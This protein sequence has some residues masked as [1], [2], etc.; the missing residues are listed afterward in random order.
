VVRDRVGTCRWPVGS[1]PA[2]GCDLA[3]HTPWPRG[4]TEAPNL[5]PLAR[6]A[7]RGKT[8]AGFRPRRTTA[9]T[10]EW[11][12]PTGHVYTVLDDPLQAGDWL[13]D[14]EPPINWPPDFYQPDDWITQTETVSG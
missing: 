6:R 2:P 9:D 10:T 13:R 8:H 4:A 5:G 3:H 14:P 1:T 7:H 12:M 11:T